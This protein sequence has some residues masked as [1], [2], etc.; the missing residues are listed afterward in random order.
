MDCS[1]PG[2]PI[3]HCLLELAQ[4]H[5]HWVGDAI[6]P[7]HPLLSPSPPAFNLSQ[8]QGLFQWVSSWHPLPFLNP[9]C[10]SGSSL[11][12]Y[13]WSLAW[14][15]LRI[16]VLHVKWAQL[17]HSWNI[18][19][20]CLSFGIGMKTNL[21]QSYDHCSVFQMCWYIEC[22]TSTASSFKIWNSA[23]PSPPLALF[24]VMLPKARL[25]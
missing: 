13:Y 4:T 22:R 17:C 23:I 16:T 8:H 9:A 18:L 21:F 12:M 15:I 1:T 14:R 20:H 10:I 2:L 7:S 24:A 5:A 6:Q 25:A 19:G 3:L 11:F